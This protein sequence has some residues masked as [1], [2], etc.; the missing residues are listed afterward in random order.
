M[1]IRQS[2]KLDPYIIMLSSP[3]IAGNLPGTLAG[4]LY[5]REIKL[6]FRE[7]GRFV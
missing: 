1:V 5:I 7:G 2:E 3:K 6:V 4:S